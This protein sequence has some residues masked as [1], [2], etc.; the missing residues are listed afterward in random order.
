MYKLVNI[1]RES[2]Q[3]KVDVDKETIAKFIKDNGITKRSSRDPKDKSSLFMANRRYWNIASENGWLDELLPKITT[4]PPSPKKLPPEELLRNR[5]IMWQNIR[6]RKREENLLKFGKRIKN[7]IETPIDDSAESEM[8]SFKALEKI[9]YNQ[10]SSMFRKYKERYPEDNLESEYLFKLKKVLGNLASRVSNARDFENFLRPVRSKLHYHDKL[11]PNDPWKKELE[12]HF[13]PLG[14]AFKRMV[15][16]FEFPDNTAYV[17]LTYNE[18][19]RKGAHLGSEKSPV[20]KH[21]QQT[22]KYPE[23]YRLV[24][25]DDGEIVKTEDLNYIEAVDAQ[26]LEH[27]A[28]EKYKEDGWKVHNIA[29]TGALGGGIGAKKTSVNNLKRFI[30]D[31]SNSIKSFN[32]IPDSYYIEDIVEKLSKEEQDKLYN[33]IKAIINKEGIKTNSELRDRGY[34]NAET[35][36]SKMKWYNS[37]FN[38][39]SSRDAPAKAA[40]SFLSEPNNLDKNQ[41]K[42]ITKRTHEQITSPEQEK[43]Y[44]TK[45]KGIIDK[46]DLK[47]PKDID[48]FTGNVALTWG[49]SDHDKKNE[50]AH[51]KSIAAIEKAK[52][53]NP[54]KDPEIEVVPLNQWK[55]IIWPDG[56]RGR[57]SGMKR[58]TP[59]SESIVDRE[60]LNNIIKRLSIKKG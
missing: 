29:K 12:A 1:L 59:I 40:E 36:I 46:Y 19:R 15:Y 33:K 35:F 56:Y 25:N 9:K 30:K 24:R 44:L 6:K 18:E 34:R 41:L 11:Y 54:N 10:M 49:L 31:E 42:L 20:F 57:G 14:N 53:K 7:W 8:N 26:K 60:V 52:E 43:I 50:I 5:K 16:V 22:G 21:I 38:T 3:E 4:R 13:I 39:K 45:L 27:D 28:L 2:L 51:D 48:D 23:F 32:L 58:K 55:D 17:G 37:L 47:R